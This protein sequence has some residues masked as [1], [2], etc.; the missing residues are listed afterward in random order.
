MSQL[1]GFESPKRKFVI[2]DDLPEWFVKKL[3]SERIKS[4]FLWYLSKEPDVESSPSASLE[5][6][7]ILQ[8]SEFRACLN[9]RLYMEECMRG[10][11][12]EMIQDIAV[13]TQLQFDNIEYCRLRKYRLTAS[14]FQAVLKA[15][16][17]G[18][19]SYKTLFLR[20]RGQLTSKP[21][22]KTVNPT[23]TNGEE[24]N[25]KIERKKKAVR[26]FRKQS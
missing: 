19:S 8:S 21:A 26:A 5:L 12:P 2:D 3:K 18:S 9:K 10:I 22:E 14:N 13:R 15:V 25:S 11:T 7:P 4:P 23:K 6:L 16:S 17:S 20:L 24:K 1:F